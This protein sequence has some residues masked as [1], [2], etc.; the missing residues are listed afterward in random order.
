VSAAICSV[1]RHRTAACLGQQEGQGAN[2][3]RREDARDGT[4]GYDAQMARRDRKTDEIRAMRALL[5]LLAAFALL[6][7]LRSG[8]R[9]LSH[10]DPSRASQLRDRA[11]PDGGDAEDAATPDESSSSGSTIVFV[12]LALGVLAF[13]GFKSGLLGSSGAQVQVKTPYL[14]PADPWADKGPDVL[15]LIAEG[16]VTRLREGDPDFHVDALLDRVKQVYLR[17]Q[18]ARFL[19][20]LSTVRA[21]MS[22]ATHQRFRTELALLDQAGQRE[23][24]A[25]V[26]VHGLQLVG[27]VQ[28]RWFDTL[29]VAVDARLRRRL[30]PADTSDADARA[31]A[32]AEFAETRVE[33]WSFVR[34]LGNRT[35]G[36]GLLE[37]KC[38]NCGAPFR[39]GHTNQCE[40]CQAIVNSGNY[41]WTLSEITRGRDHEEALR[42]SEIAG[43]PEAQRADPALNLQILEDRASLIFWKWLEARALGEPRRLS[44]LADARWLHAGQ[45][46]SP[47]A[48]RALE[49]S[50]VDTQSFLIDAHGQQ[51]VVE[52]RWHGQ[53][54]RGADQPTSWRG[55]RCRTRLTLARGP[56]VKT[57]TD[58]GMS[59]HRCPSCNAPLGDSLTPRCDFCQAELVASREDWILVGEDSL[60]LNG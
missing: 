13:A 12:A 58:N 19:R 9:P 31:Q 35:R 21:L 36:E 11:K 18:E 32:E 7:P 40:Y 54:A 15:P 3:D 56:H 60:D 20:D 4:T 29:H 57:R 47:E 59:T 37:G 33:V 52:V 14:P 17:T 38:P 6:T 50:G 42:S 1:R 34:K 30:V 51:A 28:S 10:Y 27:L 2:P 46:G 45:I 43:L 55:H 16:W 5:P 26:R 23:A 53:V 41:D 25:E 39:G 49:V 22:D 8:A 48:F 24:L 44:K